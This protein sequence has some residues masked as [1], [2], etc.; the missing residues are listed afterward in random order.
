MN[1][2]WID[3][4]VGI[5]SAAQVD[6]HEGL[7]SIVANTAHKTASRRVYAIKARKIERTRPIFNADR[8]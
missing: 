1:R 8:I 2:P 4:A 5:P 3:H 6:G 7:G